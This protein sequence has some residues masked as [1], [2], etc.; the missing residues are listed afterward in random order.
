M[1][2]WETG[3]Q[4]TMARPLPVQA[5]TTAITPHFQQPGRDAMAGVLRSLHSSMC[6]ISGNVTGHAHRLSG[7]NGCL[8]LGMLLSDTFHN[9]DIVTM[10][11]QNRIQ[12][13]PAYPTP[14]FS[15]K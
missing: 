6:G 3:Q 2:D 4:Q 15:F 1:T 14:V 10:T 8:L 11:I 12:K 9:G 7:N 13:K 5:D